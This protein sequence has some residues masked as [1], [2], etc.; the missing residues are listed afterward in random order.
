MVCLDICIENSRLNLINGDFNV[1]ESGI[2][3]IR[4]HVIVALNTFLGDWILNSDK[5][6]NYPA[7]LRDNDLLDFD[8]KRQLLEIKNVSA[9]ENFNLSFSDKNLSV[10]V[11]ATIITSYGNRLDLI[12][13]IYPY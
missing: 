10:K 4:Q 11:S 6:I 5:G 7:G 8:I 12:E 3:E 2:Q 13:T 1:L 9:I